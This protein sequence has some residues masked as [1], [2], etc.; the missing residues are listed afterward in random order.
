MCGIA[1]IAGAGAERG[2]V[3]RMTASLRHRGPDFQQVRVIEGAVLGHARLS[4]VDLSAAGNQPLENETGTVLVVANGEIYNAPELRR[5]LEARGHT[6]RSHS[7]SEVLVH[8]YEDHGPHFLPMLN[9]MFAFALWDTRDH[10]LLLARDRLGI[11]PIYF[12]E[13]HAAI[14]FA[15]EIKALDITVNDAPRLDPT[16]LAQCLAYGNQF[17]SR[18][19]TSGVKMIEPGSYLHWK[20]GR[21]KIHQYWEP[22]FSS[23]SSTAPS[24]PEACT[25]FQE[26]AEAS[27]TRHLM[28]DVDIGAYLSSG[29]DS[30]TVAVLASP[31]LSGRLTTF[32]GTFNVSGWYDESTGA[33]VVAE[34]IGAKHQDVSIDGNNLP[35]D[36]GTVAFALDEPRMGLGALSQFLVA[37]SVARSHKVVL[38]GHGGDELFAGYP[39]FKL[40]LLSR[41][42][43]N[44]IGLASACAGMRM[45]ELPHLAYF[46]GR[47]LIAPRRQHLPLPLIFGQSALNR[48]LRP[49]V[50][51]VMRDIDAAAEGRALIG[52]D[53]D[54]YSRLTL[55]YLR[56]YLPGLFV[57]EDRISMAHGLESRTPL[58]DNAMLDFSLSLPLSLK[59]HHNVLKAIPKAAMRGRLPDILWK[60]PKRGFPTP[61]GGWLRGVHREWFS[62]Q[63]LASDSPLLTL[64]QPQ[65]LASLVHQYLNGHTRHVRPLDEIPT[66]RMWMLLILDACMRRRGLHWHG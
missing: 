44:P 42:L 58:C 27:I 63:L 2:V 48:L 4:I 11:K 43:R 41:Q 64:F 34:K 3:A 30:T 6:F 49:D 24:F 54:P 53:T 60:L 35:T 47:R 37:R 51:A 52:E 46:L 40:A 65:A 29:F 62:K 36:I 57:V 10:S 28:A 26:I 17:G 33:K 55:S 16:G 39:Q 23:A 32:T 20:E 18:T 14:A 12:R 5:E 19:M 31:H 50:A 66:H 21:Q 45:S 8:L 13:M 25:Q 61:M 9:G 56:L 15:S 22:T 38:T 7:D 1:G 59:L